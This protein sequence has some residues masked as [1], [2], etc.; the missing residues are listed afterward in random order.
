MPGTS[1]AGSRDRHPRQGLIGRHDL[2]A[3]LDYAGTLVVY[4]SARGT[5]LQGV[6]HGW[7][8]HVGKGR[9][10]DADGQGS[11]LKLPPCQVGRPRV[12]SGRYWRSRSMWP[13]Q[14]QLGHWPSRVLNEKCPGF[15][16]RLRADTPTIVTARLSPTST[17]MS[18][19]L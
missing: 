7:G 14:G 18:R 1:A 13:S 11:A 19:R 5:L 16:R 4:P 2:V 17:S 15:R 10:V 6:V 8:K 12:M 3:T 9:A